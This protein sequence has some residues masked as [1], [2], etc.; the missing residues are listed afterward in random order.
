MHEIS[1]RNYPGDFSHATITAA[2][3]D[4][5]KGNYEFDLFDLIKLKQN[6]GILSSGFHLFRGHTLEGNASNKLF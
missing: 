1:G 4:S 2:Y 3:D 6:Y 5:I